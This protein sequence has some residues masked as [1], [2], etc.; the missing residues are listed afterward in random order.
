MTEPSKS[1]GVP[2]NISSQQTTAGTVEAQQTIEL[3]TETQDPQ[4]AQPTE[5]KINEKLLKAAGP[6]LK[7]DRD[8]GPPV[9]SE[10]ADRWIEVLRLGLPKEERTDL[11]KKFPPP[12]NC[13]FLEPPKLNKQIVISMNNDNV[14]DRD[15]RIIK[16]QQRLQ[17]CVGGLSTVLNALVERNKDEELP[18]IDTVA[19]VQRLIIDAIHDETGMRRSL[20][21]A[22][23][24]PAVKDT[25]T[26]TE[27]DEMLFGKNLSEDLKQLKV[28]GLDVQALSKKTMNTAAKNLKPPPRQVPRSQTTV[29]KEPQRSAKNFQKDKIPNS[30]RYRRY[31]RD[32]SSNRRY[33]GENSRRG[34]RYQKGRR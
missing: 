10:F 13:E 14:I 21:L 15:D 20:I 9:N 8:F 19:S 32:R 12:K 7:K 22:N 5:N 6:V 33:F 30:D 2:H 27:P 17:A 23:I 3:T 34:R 11:I 18:I 24:N 16:K 31:S 25:L 1:D 28:T 26:A 4:K 29:Q